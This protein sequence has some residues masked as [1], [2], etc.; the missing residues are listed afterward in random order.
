MLTE[1]YVKS[2]VGLL[3]SISSIGV[4]AIS[5]CDMSFRQLVISS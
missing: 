2:I 1:Y 4:A 5:Y 3:Y